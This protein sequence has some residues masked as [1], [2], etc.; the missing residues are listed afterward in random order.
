MIAGK[1]QL[2]CLSWSDTPGAGIKSFI[3]RW[4]GVNDARITLPGAQAKASNRP[5]ASTLPK[6]QQVL[7]TFGDQPVGRGQLK[8]QTAVNSRIE[9]T[10]NLLG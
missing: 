7:E 10:S 4:A 5:S 9:A 8:T 2:A 1:Q 3:R 6:T